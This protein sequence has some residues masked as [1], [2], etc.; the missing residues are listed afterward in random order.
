MRE[1]ASGWHYLTVE[2][3]EESIFGPVGIVNWAKRDQPIG[4][5]LLARTDLGYRVETAIPID[6]GVLVEIE[7]QSA[8]FL[9]EIIRRAP[10]RHTWVLDVKIEHRIRRS[11][12]LLSRH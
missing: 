7:T 2:Q 4:G 1:V 11:E 10:Q 12:C 3:S 9:G 6:V 8:F 5:R